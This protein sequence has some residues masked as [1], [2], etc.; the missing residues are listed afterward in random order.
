[1]A[2]NGIT[3]GNMVNEEVKIS[4][5]EIDVKKLKSETVP[6]PVVL[7]GI[8]EIGL[9]RISPVE[10]PKYLLMH[11]ALPRGIEIKANRMI[12]LLDGDLTDNVR[13]NKSNNSK[14]KEAAEYC[15]RILYDSGG[16]LFVKQFAQGAYRFGTSFA[17]LQTNMDETEVLRFEY[18]HEIFFGPARY[19]DVLKG[20]GINWGNIPMIERPLYLKKLKINP[21]T[22]K[23]AKYTQMTKKASTGELIPYGE[24]IDESMVFQLA[25]DT[26]GDEPLGISLVQFLYLTI[27]Y[28][29]SM[30][31]AGAQTMI[32]F[33]FNKWV[34]NTP[35]KDIIKMKAFSSTLAN[36][37][38]DSV[39]VLP[40]DIDLKNIE[41]G[42]TEFDRIHPIYMRLIAIRLGIP[43]TILAQEGTTTNKSTIDSLKAEM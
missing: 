28:L 21:K 43:Y 11:P 26:I 29:I 31:R 17:M 34:A 36:L 27:Q 2:E 14:A 32:N 10:I 6:N 30:E 5:H 35:F 3:G 18:E 9:K 24:E 15:K 12:K 33:G 39:V 16:P 37:Q 13:P 25:F 4:K 22:K 41:P 8:E 19:P 42:T 40:E 7:G 23:I 1:M 20:T 38:K